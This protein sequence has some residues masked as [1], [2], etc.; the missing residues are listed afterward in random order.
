VGI[1]LRRVVMGLGIE[2]GLVGGD[3]G[4]RS[5][6]SGRFGTLMSDVV[7]LVGCVFLTNNY[8]LLRPLSFFL[9]FGVMR[10][11]YERLVGTDW[12]GWK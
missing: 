12:L 11:G 3:W 7:E 8:T 2:L 4:G 9:D 6:R 5:R 10:T 1:E